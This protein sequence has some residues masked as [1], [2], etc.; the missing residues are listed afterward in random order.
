MR[1]A[2]GKV[3]LGLFLL[4]LLAGPTAAF[5]QGFGVGTMSAFA[6]DVVN[7][8]TMEHHLNFWDKLAAEL[9]LNAAQQ[10]LLDQV[11]TATRNL[12]QAS[13]KMH[14]M[15]HEIFKAEGAQPTPDVDKAVQTVKAVYRREVVPAHDALTDAEGVFYKSLTA[16]QRQKLGRMPAPE[17]AGANP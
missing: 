2:T 6:R 11:K 15:T 9:K 17:K 8:D 4:V 16:D 13:T 1:F 3:L 10:A 7:A 14:G 12:W 5:A